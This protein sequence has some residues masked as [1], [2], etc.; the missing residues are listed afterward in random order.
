MTVVGSRRMAVFDDISAT[1]KV[2]LFDSR[3]ETSESGPE[4]FAAWQVDIR[5]GD[6]TI[7]RLASPE[8]LRTEMAHFLSCIREG[9]KCRSDGATGTA[10]TAAIVAAQMSLA[11]GGEAVTLE[12]ARQG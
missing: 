10:V 3:V 11:R 1:A 5:H 9:T 4:D 2:Q 8:P 6:V 12:E 7:P